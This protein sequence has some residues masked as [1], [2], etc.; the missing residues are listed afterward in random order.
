MNVRMRDIQNSHQHDF[1]VS[2][3][4]VQLGLSERIFFSNV[5]VSQINIY[6]IRIM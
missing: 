2:I 1:S 6:E 3:L 5:F 4:F